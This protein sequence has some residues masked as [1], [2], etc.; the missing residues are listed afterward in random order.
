MDTYGSRRNYSWAVFLVLVGILLL[1]NTTE[2]VGWG[3]WQYIVRFWPVFIVLIGIKI[4]LGESFLARALEIF[5]TILLTVAVFGVAYIQYTAKGVQFLPKSVNEWI[6]EG[7]SGMFNLT[8]DNVQ[9]EIYVSFDEYQNIVERNLLLKMGAGSMNIIEDGEANEYLRIKQNHPR[10]YEDSVLEQSE[11]NG[12][13]SL[14]FLSASPKSFNL[15]P[16]ESSYDI[17][18]GQLSL[19]TTLDI[20]IGTGSGE[21]DLQRLPVK[22]FY[23]KIGA[24]NFSATFSRYSLPSGD[25]FFNIGTGKMTLYIPERIGYMFEYDLGVGQINVEGKDISDFSTGRGKYTSSNYE[26]ADIK[27]D[28]IVNVGVGSFTIKTN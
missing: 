4:I 21:L 16:N 28:M 11:M 27:L 24:G 5:F 26:D 1:L 3:I 15:F 18:I 8:E 23:T 17:S 6:L 9:S 12:A 19:P 25:I 20:D 2:V 10:V 22:D 14:N 13:L 7:G